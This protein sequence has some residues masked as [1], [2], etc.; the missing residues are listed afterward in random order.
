MI[1]AWGTEAQAPNQI[2]HALVD[3]GHP[4]NYS[5]EAMQPMDARMPMSSCAM[6]KPAVQLATTHKDIAAYGKCAAFA[7]KVELSC[8]VVYLA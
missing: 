4:F 3:P 7:G 1:R 6:Y 8:L 2:V 5:F